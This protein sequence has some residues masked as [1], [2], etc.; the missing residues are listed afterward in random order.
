MHSHTQVPPVADPWKRVRRIVLLL[1]A[2]AVVVM[3]ALSFKKKPIAV[4]VAKVD[5]GEFVEVVEEPG[6]TRVRERFVISAPVSGDLARIT[7]KPGDAV[8]AQDVLATIRPVAPAM[9]DARQKGELEARLQAALASKTLSDASVDKAKTVKSFAEKEVARLKSLV[10]KGASPEH[11]L[12]KAELDLR[13]AEKDLKTAELSAHVASHE[14]D[15]ARAATT[16]SGGKSEAAWPVRSPLKGRVLRVLQT[17]EGVVAAGTP[18]LEVADP[19]DLEVVVG[20]LT[21]DA[22][23]ITPGARSILERWGGPGALEGRVRSVEPSGY[24]K[25]SALGVEEQ[26]VDVVIDIVSPQNAWTTLGDGFRVHTRTIVFRQ[27][28]ALKTAAATLFRDGNA[29]AL[30]VVEKG[31]AAK[32]RVTVER[33]NGPEVVLSGLPQGTIVVNFPT[34]ALHDGAPV[35]VP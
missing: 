2:A 7:K 25:L 6:K 17:S 16:V 33:R 8:E 1:L 3:I 34:S 13:V 18:L 20:V 19:T 9:M 15:V 32:R 22:V 4:E 5:K 24:T 26:R 12:E 35:A 27:P 14:V 31:R 30:F 23:R 10:E 11:D 28:D 21:S 29:W